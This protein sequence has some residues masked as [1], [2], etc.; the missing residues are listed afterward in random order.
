MIKF[1]KIT[2]FTFCL[3]FL[4]LFPLLANAQI[5]PCGGSN[6][7]DCQLCH[8]FVLISNI[9]DF[10]LMYIA[11]LAG[12][13]IVV[14]GIL[15]LISRGAELA[16]QGKKMITYAVIGIV[17]A[18]L[19]WTI[20]N[21]VMTVLIGSSNVSPLRWPWNDPDIRCP[22]VSID[23]SQ[24]LVT[25]YE[26]VNGNT[27]HVP[28]EYE[29]NDVDLSFFQF[30]K[31][32]FTSIIKT[33]FAQ[34]QGIS[35]GDRI[36]YTATYT[37][38]SDV[39]LSNLTITIDYDESQI[40]GPVSAVSIGGVD[41]D[42]QINWD[43]DDL[44]SG[45]SIT[46]SFEFVLSTDVSSFL[47]T[48]RNNTDNFLTRIFK[49]IFKPLNK[50]ASAQQPVT[51][52]HYYNLVSISSNEA[53]P[54]SL[55]DP[56]QITIPVS[57]FADRQYYQ[58]RNIGFAAITYGDRLRYNISYYNPTSFNFNDVYIISDYNQDSINVTNVNGGGIDDGDKITWYLGNLPAGYPGQNN[59]GCIGYEFLV[60]NISPGT[61]R[62]SNLFY[63]IYDQGL[64]E[65]HDDQLNVRQ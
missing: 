62:I 37:N 60:R 47:R 23:P 6:D 36:R 44:D 54:E 64:L 61:N 18:L 49:K 39:N 58:T 65:T 59:P 31:N 3:S 56:L 55:N 5:V 24:A 12:V 14:G 63:I 51:T 10:I 17:I 22:V 29:K 57:I 26:R 8:F 16:V 4:V 25:S 52:A 30:L 46:V 11:P 7:I 28:L 20:V 32:F 9:V 19:G 33:S 13:F 21:T 48:S 53:V 45:Q 38:I 27:S 15:I 41:D 34:V 42:N 2:I 1:I 50:N 43:I 35:I 40:S